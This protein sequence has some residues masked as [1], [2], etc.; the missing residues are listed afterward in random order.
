[1]TETMQEKMYRAD[2]IL[3]AYDSMTAAQIMLSERNLYCDEVQSEING[4]HSF[5]P[6]VIFP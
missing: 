1:M 6:K 4:S 5:Q 2:K 3:I